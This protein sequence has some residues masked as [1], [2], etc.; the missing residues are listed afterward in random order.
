MYRIP[1]TT[2]F[3]RWT[4][5]PLFMMPPPVGSLSVEKSISAWPAGVVEAAAAA[6]HCYIVRDGVVALGQRAARVDAAALVGGVVRDGREA[7]REHARARVFDAAADA[8]QGSVHHVGGLV[9]GDGRVAHG[10]HRRVFDA[11]AEIPATFWV[12]VALVRVSVALLAMPAPLSAVLP[13]T[14]V[15][16]IVS[17]PLLSMPPPA[18]MPAPA[19]VSWAWLD[20][21]FECLTVSIPVAVL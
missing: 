17:V 16:L 21:I 10:E 18:P 11:A 19:I 20:E 14:V 1:S 9:I 5:L 2:V 3:L 15:W 12:M 4:V 7:E 8:E 6:H 13:E